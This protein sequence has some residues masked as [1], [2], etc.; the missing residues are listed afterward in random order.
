MCREVAK[1]WYKLKYFNLKLV[2]IF[3]NNKLEQNAKIFEFH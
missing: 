3:I 1:Y 2:Y